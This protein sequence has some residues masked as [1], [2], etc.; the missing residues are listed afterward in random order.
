MH[1]WLKTDSNAQRLASDW[2]LFRENK[3]V[4]LTGTPA[5]GI[6]RSPS[7]TIEMPNA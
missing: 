4:T 3:R 6:N 5:V 7:N 1:C 2:T